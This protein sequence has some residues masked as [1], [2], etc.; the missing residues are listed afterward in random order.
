[1]GTNTIC[2]DCGKMLCK[3][4]RPNKSG[5]CG[6][7]APRFL[8]AILSK[9]LRK[10]EVIRNGNIYVRDDNGKRIL[11]YV[12]VLR[13]HN[14]FVPKQPRVIF[15]DGNRLNCSYENLS[16]IETIAVVDCSICGKTRQL[17]TERARYGPS[18]ASTICKPCRDKESG[19]RL[20]AINK[21]RITPRKVLTCVSCGKVRRVPRSTRHGKTGYCINC[22]AKNQAN[23]RSPPQTTKYLWQC[24]DCGKTK[25]RVPSE[26]AQRCSTCSVQHLKI[27]IPLREKHYWDVLN[28]KKWDKNTCIDCGNYRTRNHRK[29]ASLRCWGCYLNWSNTY[30]TAKRLGVSYEEAKAMADRSRSRVEAVETK[31]RDTV[32]PC[33]DSDV[34][35][36]VR[37]V[38]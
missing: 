11:K 28:N 3:S 2:Y 12:K 38:S 26:K 25:L 24:I 4:Y 32:R 17:R 35:R 14:I 5:R 7:C 8:H 13:D 22:Y 10:T 6:K 21:S 33:Q 9:K 1:M 27:R 29:R 20:A 31:S 34:G 18:G 30:K 37:R 16:I 15:L 23:F 36:K 19:Q